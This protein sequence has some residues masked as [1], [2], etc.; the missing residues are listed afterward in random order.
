MSLH[1]ALSSA[2]LLL[3]A[4]C[5]APVTAS[6]P[7]IA[8]DPHSHAEPERVRV[9]HVSLDLEIRFDQRMLEGSATLELERPDPT[10]PLVLDARDLWVTSVLTPDGD[11]RRFVTGPPDPILGSALVIDLEPGDRAV[12]VFYRTYPQAPALQWLAPSQTA[13]G[14]HPF[15]YTQGQSIL[16]RT[17]IPLQDS[18]GVRVTFDAVLRAP[19]ETTAVMAAEQ[20]GRGED[21]AFRFRM[22]HPIPP[23]LIA[24]ACGDLAFRPLSERCGV[25]AEPS[26]VDRAAAELSDTE[27]MVRAAEDLFGPYRWG[28]YDLLVLPPSF[29]FGGME[30]PRLTFA[31]PTIL[32]GD[33]SLV[34]LVA[35]ELA[36]SWSGNLVTNATWRDF[37]L[38]EGFTVYLEGRIMEAV[39][40][41]D[42][43]RMEQQLG[44]RELERELQELP[45]AEQ[46]LHIDLTGRDPDDGFSQVP[47]EKGA[48]FLR[49]LEEIFGRK[50]FDR[51]LTGYFDAHAFQSLTTE[52]FVAYLRERLLEGD[53]EKAS[54]IDLARW[55]EAP[56]LPEDAPSQRSDALARAEAAVQAFGAGTPPERLD[57][58]GFV[59]Q[60]W[61]HFLE[62]LPVGVGAAELAR[63][64]GAFR[65]TETGNS[66]ILCVWLRRSIEAGY[67]DADERLERFLL[68]VGRRKY[69][70][71]LY[72]ALAK[73]EEGK[74]RARRIYEQA[75]PRYHSV[76][77]GTI[78][79][80]LR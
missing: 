58:S 14:A 12:E 17:W 44:R 66:E 80:I 56:G 3:A 11:P 15:V 33:K 13:G 61:I 70:K 24:M 51:F 20:L 2:S 7:R 34:A 22:D 10:A 41:V 46:V 73:T 55:I 60:Q 72:T 52:R 50:V 29:P 38:N 26:V 49:R 35:H 79:E 27:A 57:V 62:S 77:T 47:Y 37:W 23:Y 9:R 48:L 36:H 71:P 21:G 53:P 42:R 76:S 39:F 65:L 1:R 54:R 78:D 8:L 67:A 43:A 69:L 32:A 5:A 59:T 30:N 31:T 63:L 75:R 25:W 16:T 74:A 40:G 4:A 64:D 45:L 68:E 28:R 18:P 6:R 19:R